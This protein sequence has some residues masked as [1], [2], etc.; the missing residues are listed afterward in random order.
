MILLQNL[1]NFLWSILWT[2]NHLKVA[3]SSLLFICAYLFWK[4]SLLLMSYINPRGSLIMSG[5]HLSALPSFKMPSKLS[6]HKVCNFGGAKRN[7]TTLFVSIVPEGF[8]KKI[9][10]SSKAITSPGVFVVLAECHTLREKDPIFSN[11]LDNSVHDSC[12]I[13]NS[14]ISSNLQSLLS[15]SPYKNKY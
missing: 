7:I 6:I 5:I 14:H 1:Q 9:W 12:Y 3:I 10:A 8:L 11:I 2:R 13:S 15:N 4:G